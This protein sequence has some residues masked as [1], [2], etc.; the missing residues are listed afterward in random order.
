MLLG[1]LL[2]ILRYSG[3]TTGDNSGAHSPT[4]NTAVTADETATEAE[5]DDNQ[6]N[7]SQTGSD[8]DGP[9]SDIEHLVTRRQSSSRRC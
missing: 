3:A 4:S 8:D 2:E 1:V 7:V 9:P 6:Q 5:T